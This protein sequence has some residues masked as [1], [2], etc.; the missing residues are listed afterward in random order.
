MKSLSLGALA[1]LHEESAFR[2][3]VETLYVTPGISTHKFWVSKWMPLPLVF[4]IR[5]HLKAFLCETPLKDCSSLALIAVCLTWE[6][7]W[8]YD[9]GPILYFHVFSIIFPTG[10]D[11]PKV[12]N[13]C[14]PQRGAPC[15]FIHAPLLLLFTFAEHHC[16]LLSVLSGK[17]SKTLW[18]SGFFLA[19]NNAKE[20]VWM[21]FIFIKGLPCVF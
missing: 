14:L 10:C 9:P 1:L 2:Q 20:F 8:T 18:F 11:T 15:F 5:V 13:H 4:P 21:G 7:H 12:A 6:A 16:G 17:P 3:S 19:S